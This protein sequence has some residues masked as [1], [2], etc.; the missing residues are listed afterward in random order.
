MATFLAAGGNFAFVIG[1][2]IDQA[3]PQRSDFNAVSNNRFNEKLHQ[4]A[5]LD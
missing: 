3:S 1:K 4:V 2:S 5:N